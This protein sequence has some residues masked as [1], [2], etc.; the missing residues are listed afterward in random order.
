LPK[1]KL[2]VAVIS[3]GNIEDQ[4]LQEIKQEGAPARASD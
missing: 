2:N 4:V 1:T 3:G